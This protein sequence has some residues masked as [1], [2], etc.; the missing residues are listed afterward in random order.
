MPGESA[1][2]WLHQRRE[3]AAEIA[4]RYPGNDAWFDIVKRAFL[5]FKDED[6]TLADAC[7]D[8]LRRRVKGRR[9]GIPWLEVLRCDVPSPVSPYYDPFPQTYPEIMEAACRAYACGQTT[10]VRRCRDELARQAC[11]RARL[12]GLADALSILTGET[13]IVSRGGGAAF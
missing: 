7:E 13:R 3:L 6:S 4:L 9:Y 5:A 10:A 1:Q 8:A 11:G 2:Q 12:R